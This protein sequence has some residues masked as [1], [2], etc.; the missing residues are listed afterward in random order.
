MEWKSWWGGGSS[1]RVP[2]GCRRPSRFATRHPSPVSQRHFLGRLL[3]QEQTGSRKALLVIGLML[4]LASGC[5]LDQSR[6]VGMYR[7]ILAERSPPPA[8]EFDPRA[9]L[10]L[11]AALEIANERS[12][13]LAMEGE[14]YVQSVIDKDRALS[15]FLPTV[16]FAPTYIRQEKTGIAQ[17][18]LF[19]P[20][21]ALD[22]PLTGALGFNLLQNLSD[23]EQGSAAVERQRQ[24][25]LDL[26]TTV[27]LDVSQAYYQILRS[28]RQREVLRSSIATQEERV[29]NTKTMLQNGMAR[30]LDVSQA[31]AEL[32]ATRSGLIRA[33]SDV[34]NGRAMLA[35]LMGVDS[36]DG[37]LSDDLD[38]PSQLPD[39]RSLFQVAETRRRDLRAARQQVQVSVDGL[40]SAWSEFF[41]S[42]TVD[43][44][45]FLQ[46][47]T[48]PTDVSWA[49]MLRVNIPI[50]TAGLIYADIRDAWSRVRQDRSS[51][52]LLE[53]GIRKEIRVADEDLA[54]SGDQI[55]ELGVQVTAAQEALH[56]A[57]QAYD[58][59]LATNLDRL[60]AQDRL[61]NAQLQLTSEQLSKK[62]FYLR[63]LRDIGLLDI[64]GL[65]HGPHFDGR[66][67]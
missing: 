7:Q 2:S 9:P 54:S 53:R 12:E 6:E 58:V 66:G 30:P 33:G 60:V 43:F 10:S 21:K 15:A 16:S 28:E 67:D 25:L 3:A 18:A 65:R 32:S 44:T 35:Y 55:T 36:V 13:R 49:S 14:K 52:A 42:V 40:R 59:G 8:S 17:A 63:V 62:I 61:Q 22:L 11:V 64:D 31:E 23:V 45:Y 38:V 50:F 5:G 51:L 29:R 37:A 34:R 20:D 56:Q 4:L 48:F 39:L 27:W 26:Q 46:R 24:L 57:E 47:E 19:E 41:P 1:S